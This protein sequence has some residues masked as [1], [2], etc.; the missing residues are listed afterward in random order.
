MGCFG[1]L[2]RVVVM[3]ISV[4]CVFVLIVWF[5]LDV[6]LIKLFLCVFVLSCV[7]KKKMQ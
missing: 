1:T 2:L 5:L 3:Y 4:A 7:L 6:C